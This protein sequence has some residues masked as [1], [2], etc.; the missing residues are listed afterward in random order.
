MSRLPRRS[1]VGARRP[2]LQRPAPSGC[3]DEAPSVFVDDAFNLA[4]SQKFHTAYV[5]HANLH[6][7]VLFDTTRCSARRPQ[8]CDPITAPV[9]GVS[10][11]FDIAFDPGTDTLYATNQDDKSLVLIDPATCNAR[12]PTG[13]APVA[14]VPLAD[15]LHVAVDPASHAVWVTDDDHGAV[16]YIDGR[17]CNVRDRTGCTARDR[18][19]RQPGLWR[20]G[21][22]DDRQRVCLQPL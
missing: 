7:V 5:T 15:A 14:T 18:P 2:R 12:R 3:R 4:I 22:F 16:S 17:R 10:G 1:R 8:G 6:D 21:R 20:H 9:Q 19:R 13:C 11:P